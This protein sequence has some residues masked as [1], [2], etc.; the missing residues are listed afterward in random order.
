M[1]A[2]LFLCYVHNFCKHTE[3]ERTQSGAAFEERRKSSLQSEVMGTFWP[4]A[5]RKVTVFA[6]LVARARELDGAATAALKSARGI[7]IE[8]S[9]WLSASATT[10]ELRA[11]KSTGARRRGRTT[12]AREPIIFGPLIIS[13]LLG[14]SFGS[15]LAAIIAGSSAVCA[16]PQRSKRRSLS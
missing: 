16:R 13:T 1:P 12:I 11:Q 8:R 15:R 10:A 7:I 3:S 2:L 4:G 9:E 5:S 6:V 14:C